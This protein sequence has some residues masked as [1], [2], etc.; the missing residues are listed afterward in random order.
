[1]HTDGSCSQLLCRYVCT[2]TAAILASSWVMRRAELLP[3]LTALLSLAAM[4][5]VLL[6]VLQFLP[7]I[8]PSHP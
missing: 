2:A 1:M 7:D 4:Y 6:L 3:N 5:A 8:R